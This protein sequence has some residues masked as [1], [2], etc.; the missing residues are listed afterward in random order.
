V[1]QIAVLSGKGG[2]GKTTVT[3]ALAHLASQNSATRALL[4]DADVDAANLELLLEPKIVE[5]YDFVGGQVATIDHHLCTG[6]GRCAEVCRFDSIRADDGCYSVNETTCEGCAT[7]K[8]QCPNNAIA[9]TPSISGRWFYS[10]SRYGPLFHARLAPAQESSG[11]LVTL[12]KQRAHAQAVRESFPL[13]LVDGPPGIGCPAIAAVSGA[14]VVIV[15]TEPTAAGIHDMQRAL[16]LAAHFGISAL[17][18]VNKADLYQAGTNSIVGYCQRKDLTLIG[19]LP[20]D[21]SATE[22]MVCGQT[23]SAYAPNGPVS[24]ALR[25]VWRGTLAHL[26]EQAVVR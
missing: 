17:V 8:T 12:L 21:L 3:A 9:M 5:A 6:C 24:R 16:D 1:K 23:I 25:E 15:V 13:M 22:A 18:C 26:K 14:D 2:T 11:K 4:V 10:V 20:F 19:L 7:C